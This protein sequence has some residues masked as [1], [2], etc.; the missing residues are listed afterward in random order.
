VWA[1]R[2]R[3]REVR[4]LGGGCVEQQSS[5]AVVAAGCRLSAKGNA[6]TEECKRGWCANVP[7]VCG[8]RLLRGAI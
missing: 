7:D 2:E 1:E 5:A 8:G 3:K 6:A 4:V